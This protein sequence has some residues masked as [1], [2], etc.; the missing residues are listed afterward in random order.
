MDILYSGNPA[1]QI[2]DQL[3]AILS[4]FNTKDLPP[5]TPFN[6]SGAPGE[7]YGYEQEYTTNVG[8]L[9]PSNLLNLVK[10]ITATEYWRE[11]LHKNLSEDIFNLIN[12]V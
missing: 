5:L 3:L 9:K 10:N 4:T 12:F 2:R 6:Y 1:G 7:D 11:Y 8:D